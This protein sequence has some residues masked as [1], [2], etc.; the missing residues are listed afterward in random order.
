MALE[1]P[2]PFI[3]PPLGE[4]KQSIIV[5]H[6]RGDF[7][8]AFGDLLLLTKLS[9]GRTFRE[10]M[11]NAK[12]IFPSAPLYFMRPGIN[13]Y[14]WF[15]IMSLIDPNHKQE[16]QAEGLVM[17]S[18]I[19]HELIR[20]EV[21]AVGVKNVILGG[22]SQG[23]A[24]ALISLA[25]WTGEPFGAAFGMSGWLPFSNVL[26]V[27]GEQART[28]IE[29]APETNSQ[30]D[31]QSKS[32]DQEA[33]R[34]ALTALKVALDIERPESDAILRTPIFIGHGTRDLVVSDELGLEAAECLKS[35]GCKV[36]W[37]S[38]EGL[39]HWY[40][41]YEVEEIVN[42]IKSNIGLG[43]EAA[44]AVAAEMMQTPLTGSSTF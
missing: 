6:G 31:D 16:M 13:S 42:F 5:L 14:E 44:T 2:Q 20:K 7:G 25:L 9:T 1:H 8:D 3:V 37:R 24:T 22:L 38:Y 11:A 4:H 17:S 41:D 28:K 29:S 19:V 26:R 23:C 33:G 10:E 36:R 30:H 40:E 18:R 34:A 15:E 35:I 32:R 39:R 21:E 27:G 43:I 12:F